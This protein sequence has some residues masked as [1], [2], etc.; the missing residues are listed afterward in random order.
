MMISACVLQYDDISLP[1]TAVSVSL[2]C[3]CSHVVV[4]GL[5]VKLSRYPM[6]MHWL[7]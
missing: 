2:W 4:F 1:S 3:A 6:W 7:L 5:S